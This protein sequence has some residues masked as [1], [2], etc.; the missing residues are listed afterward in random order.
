LNPQVQQLYGQKIQELEQAIAQ[1]MQAQQQA[2]MGMIP[3]DGYLTTVNQSWTNPTTGK[4]ERIKLP[5]ASIMW[6]A[7]KL[8]QQ[9]A[10]NQ[11]LGENGGL[12]QADI[13]AQQQPQANQ[14][15]MAQPTAPQ[16]QGE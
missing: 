15:P 2:N 3:A 10:F 9:G 11:S 14:V 1:K 16:V 8:N 7:E 5:T 13:A 12:I 6:L 4:V